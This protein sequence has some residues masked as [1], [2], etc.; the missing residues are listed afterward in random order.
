MPKL[1]QINVVSNMLST[2]KICE[3]IAKVAQKHGWQT[4]IAYGRWA[5]PGI[6]KANRVGTSFDMY[7][8]YAQHR[9]LIMRD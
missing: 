5:K 8:H 6:Q 4:Y 3:D 1:F 7:V 2:G 9:F